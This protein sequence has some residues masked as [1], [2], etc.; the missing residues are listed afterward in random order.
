MADLTRTVAVIFQGVDSSLS[1]ATAQIESSLRGVS[2]AAGSAAPALDDT[3]AASTRLGTAVGGAGGSIGELTRLMQGL[4]GSLVVKEFIDANVAIENFGRAMT[5]VTGSTEG[6]AESLSYIKSIS[7]TLGLE[8]SGT[9]DNFV[10][11]S[12][13]AKGTALEGQATRDIFEAVS[14]AMS[15]LGK[16]SSDTQGALLAIQQ[17]ISKGT[18]SAE[19][20]RGQLGERLPGAFQLAA[21]AM[22]VTTAELGKLLEGGNVVATDLLPKLAA[23][24]NKTFGETTYVTTFNAELNRLINSLKE[25]AVAGGKSGLFAD[26]T[27]SLVDVASKNKSTVIEVQLLTGAFKATRDFLASGGKDWDEYKAAMQRVSIEAGITQSEFFK[28]NEALAETKRLARSGTAD[29]I[30]WS[31]QVNES[32]AESKRLG[33]EGTGAT[34]ALVDA[35]KKL[36]FTAKSI[37]ADFTAAF[38]LIVKSADSTG[39]EISKALKVVI[40]KIDNIDD[41]ERAVAALAKAATDGKITWERYAVEVDKS[42]DA[43]LK[44]TGYVKQTTSAVQDQTAGFAVATGATETF[45]IST[46]KLARSNQ[47]VFAAVEDVTGK[48]YDISASVDNV[49]AKTTTYVEVNKRL[50]DGYK[51]IVEVV[52]ASTG[53]IIGYEQANVKA[54]ATTDKATTAAIKSAAE[55]EKQKEAVAKLAL[56]LEKIASNERIK[57]MEF[58]ANIDVARIKADAEKVQA[59]FA[60]INVGIESTGDMLGKLFGLFDKL[61]NLDSTAYRAVFDQID[62]ENVL[63]EKSF[64]LQEKLTQAQ[65]DNLN[66]QTKALASGDAIIKIDGAGLQPHL[67][68]FMWEILKAVQ[69][70]ANRDGLAFLLGV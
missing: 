29:L 68:A 70:R 65:I 42:A 55:L 8:I 61:G 15:L 36:G 38:E 7:N 19:E 34:A 11:L 10:S 51:N 49:G 56:E 66:A 32:A 45:T 21:R 35:Y 33:I 20:L 28:T 54:T 31:T 58:K 53:K 57:T 27:Q 47:T 14:K 39:D 22:D 50:V 24:L 6:A 30:D 62:K 41:L 12:A 16:S 52:D 59:A 17:M 26:L 9:A 1:Q 67:E 2:T 46:E 37:G 48:L 63:R 4:A 40:P 23:E 13:A 60:S 43:F 5:L 44:N 64:Q 25:L 69:V 3:A 18:V